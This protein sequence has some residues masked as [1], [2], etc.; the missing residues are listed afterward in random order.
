M[1]IAE[2]LSFGLPIVTTRLRGMV[3]YLLENENAILV[4]P[5]EPK[6]LARA[7]AKLLG[8]PELRRSMS[9]NNRR[10]A[11]SFDPEVVAEDYVSVLNEVAEGHKPQGAAR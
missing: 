9:L 1:A 4:S 10:T 8:D 2:A 11:S 3:D 6:G 5:G 7:L